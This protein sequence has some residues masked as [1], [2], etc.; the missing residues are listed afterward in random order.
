MKISSYGMCIECNDFIDSDGNCVNLV[1]DPHES[2]YEPCEA[3][4][5]N[6]EDQEPC[7]YCDNL[8]LRPTVGTLRRLREIEAQEAAINPCMNTRIK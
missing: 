1:D 6:N 2:G 7:W 5:Y 4:S 3:C 8:G